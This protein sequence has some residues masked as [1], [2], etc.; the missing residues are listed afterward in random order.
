MEVGVLSGDLVGL[1]LLEDLDA[2]LGLEVVLHPE[3]LAGRVDPLVGVRAEAVHVAPR[4][5]QA[6]VAHEPGDLVGGLG[7][8]RPEVPLHVVV[9]EVRAR[10]ALLRADEVGE[11]DPVADEEDGRVVADEVVV[12]LVRVELQREA[13]GVAPRVGAALLAG[14][15]GEARE[16]LDLGAGLEEGGAR[17]GAHVARDA[18]GAER[19]AALGVDDALRDALAVELRELLDEVVV[20][21]RD[22]A[23][24][25]DGERVLVAGDRGA[26]VGGRVLLVG[27]GVSPVS[28][29]T[30]R[31]WLGWSAEGRAGGDR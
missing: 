7:R 5:G 19:P 2:L 11:L 24:G 4:G 10:Q 26:G 23:V 14:D 12:A 18:E 1:L 31:C 16:H 15:G 20:V 3:A 21:Q 17:V 9:A 13:A 29:G 22:G 25:P 27:H 6:A 28:G 30:G 8:E